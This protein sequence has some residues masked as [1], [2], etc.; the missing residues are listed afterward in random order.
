MG[1][2]RATYK[3]AADEVYRV[4]GGTVG[5]TLGDTADMVNRPVNA[6]LKALGSK[7]RVPMGIA[8]GAVPQPRTKLNRTI[9]QVAPYLSVVLKFLKP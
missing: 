6:A 1:K 9:R 5:D 7:Y 3:D 2:K 8:Q 4:Y